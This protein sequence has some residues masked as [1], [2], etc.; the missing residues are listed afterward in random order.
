[1]KADENHQLSLMIEHDQAL[2]EKLKQKNHEIYLLTNSE[3][4]LATK[5][6]DLYA[7]VS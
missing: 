1:M 7:L 4:Q 3:K 5:V 2:Q 6:T